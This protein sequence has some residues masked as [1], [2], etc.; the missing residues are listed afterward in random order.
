MPV[1]HMELALGGLLVGF[2]TRMGSGCTSGHGLCGLSRFSPRSGVAVGT[3]MA[4]G[5]ATAYISHNTGAL[6][7]LKTTKFA[8]EL[9]DTPMY[10]YIGSAMLAAYNTYFWFHN[11]KIQLPALDR[12]HMVE[13]LA[14]FLSAMVFGVGLGISGMCDPARVLN[15][16]NFAGKSGFDPSL[17]G[18]MGG[19]VVV[20]TMTNWYLHKAELDA[21]LAAKKISHAKVLKIG[22]HESNMKIDYNLVV[23]SALFGMGWG[24]VGMCPGPA[25]VSWAGSVPNALY[26]VP[27][28]MTGIAI[29]HQIFEMENSWGISKKKIW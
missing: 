8:H 17:A 16:L 27:F 24:M 18:V 9:L 28:L 3:F 11:K 20:N 12:D 19:G 4:T 15:F 10:L 21:P 7:V 14:Y 26:F 29:R 22:T 2:G 23:G 1:S 6:D 13:N 5:A 25:L